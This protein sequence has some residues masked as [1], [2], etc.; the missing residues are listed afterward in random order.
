MHLEDS[1]VMY[2]INNVET[3]K[4][5]INTVHHIHNTISFNEKLFVGQGGT[6]TLQPLYANA[7]DIQH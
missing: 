2:G 6:A 3:P 4:Q 7:Q 1:M 5:L